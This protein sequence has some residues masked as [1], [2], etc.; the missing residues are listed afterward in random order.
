MDLLG[1]GGVIEAVGKVA[2]DLITTDKEKMQLELEAKKLE[3][4]QMR[5]EQAN[6]LAQI[7]VN[8]VEAA[9]ASLFVSGWRPFIGWGCGFA[10]LYIGILEPI[11]RFAA[12]VVWAYNGSFPEIDPT[13]TMQVLFG[14]LG[15]AG[16]RTYEK[17]QKVA[18][19]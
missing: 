19:K 12:K 1:I 13:I 15:L 4:E 17:T 16:M 18:S 3:L 14:L 11:A 7:D 9:S 2:G 6:N 8:K 10:F 5:I